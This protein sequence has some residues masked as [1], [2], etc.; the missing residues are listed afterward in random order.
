MNCT[1]G[2]AGLGWAWLRRTFHAQCAQSKGR[3]ARDCGN[4][5]IETKL[6][7]GVCSMGECKEI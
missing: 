5:K 6:K 7:V 2:L 4:G 3:I 1:V